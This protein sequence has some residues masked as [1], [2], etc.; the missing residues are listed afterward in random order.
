MVKNPIIHIVSCSPRS[1][2]TLFH[3]IMVNCFDIDLS[4][5]SE[6]SIFRAGFIRN[7]LTVIKDPNEIFYM[8]YMLAIEP[9][10][11]VIYLSRDPRDVISSIHRGSQE[12]GYFTGVTRWI[13]YQQEFDK[14]KE[15]PRVVEVRYEDLVSSPDE[16]QGKLLNAFPF[17]V[18]RKAFSSYHDQAAPSELS[19]VAM[20]GL[21]PISTKSLGGWKKNLERIKQQLV[22]CPSLPDILINYGYERDRSW[23]ELLEGVSPLPPGNDDFS[24]IYSVKIRYR[25]FRKCF[26][27][28][29]SK[30]LFRF[31]KA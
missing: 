30:L 12:G 25:I 4:Y 14:I 26:W 9:R 15:H 27:Y 3:E 18:K 7:G 19:L 24:S 5:P 1:G 13:E 10:L 11:H 6:K 21:R 31:S 23:L 20:N 16:I 22:E 29:L 8:K 28:F 2:T 17:L